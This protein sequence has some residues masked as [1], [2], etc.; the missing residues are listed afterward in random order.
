LPHRLEVTDRVEEAIRRAAAPAFR[1]IQID[2]VPIISAG[3]VHTIANSISNNLTRAPVAEVRGA[4]EYSI[5]TGFLFEWRTAL[6]SL[7][8]SRSP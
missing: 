8:P 6:I 5:I 3:D 4:G 1:T 7:M 2:S